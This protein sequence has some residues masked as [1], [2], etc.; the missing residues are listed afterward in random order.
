[1]NY[2]ESRQLKGGPNA[3][4]WNYTCM[5]DGIIYPVGY[6]GGWPTWLDE[7]ADPSPLLPIHQ[8]LERERLLN[9]KPKF[10]EHP[11]ETPEEAQACYKMYL[12]DTAMRTVNDDHS[13]QH[14]AVCG[15]WTQTV[16]SV[17]S[18][19]QY[20]LCPVHANRTEVEKLFTVGSFASS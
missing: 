13:K 16:V 19:A 11:H 2:Y 15:E 9:F 17:V 14:C 10:H 6:C 18:H 8:T 5:N 4:K 3:G 12:L 1:M 7:G 20:R